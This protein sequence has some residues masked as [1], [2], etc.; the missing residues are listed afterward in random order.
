MLYM[1][2]AQLIHTERQREI[3]RTLQTRRLLAVT[4]DPGWNLRHGPSKSGPEP[5]L[6][7]PQEAAGAAS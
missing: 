7:G 2:I 6:S 5:R 1:A 4:D 3:E